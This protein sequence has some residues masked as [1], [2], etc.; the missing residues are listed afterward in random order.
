MA[1][2]G[3]IPNFD[4]SPMGVPAGDGTAVVVTITGGTVGMP[5]GTASSEG[6]FEFYQRAVNILSVSGIKVTASGATSGM[7]AISG[8]VLSGMRNLQREFAARAADVFPSSLSAARR[9]S[10]AQGVLAVSGEIQVGP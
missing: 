4:L 5:N 10:I 6:L 2:S 9:L 3:V 7:Q 1:L 8:S